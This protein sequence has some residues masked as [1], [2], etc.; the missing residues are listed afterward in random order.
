MAKKELDNLT[1][2]S[3]EALAAGMT[4][5]KYMAMKYEQEQVPKVKAPKPLPG[6]RVCRHCGKKF[7]A[8]HGNRQYC[9]DICSAN[10][11]YK[12]QR[13][14]ITKNQKLIPPKIC[15]TCG[16]EFIPSK[17]DKRIKYCGNECRNMPKWLHLIG[18]TE[19]RKVENDGQRIG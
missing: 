2:C 9:S 16:K 7:Y 4:Y 10:A 8:S 17:N 13:D 3:N 15:A 19:E 14:K 11:H 18:I 5:G 12:M 1:R 6:W